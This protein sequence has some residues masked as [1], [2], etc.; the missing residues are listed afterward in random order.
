[1]W[2]CAKFVYK[3]P[4][5]GASNWSSSAWRGRTHTSQLIEKISGCKLRQEHCQCVSLF[6]PTM[7]Q[8]FTEASAAY[9]IWKPGLNSSCALI[10]EFR[11]GQG[12]QID[13]CGTQSFE[14]QSDVLLHCCVEIPNLS[15]PLCWLTSET[16]WQPVRLWLPQASGLLQGHQDRYLQTT[17]AFFLSWDSFA[18]VCFINFSILALY[19]FRASCQ[20]R[21]KWQLTN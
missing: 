3:R 15:D 20:G 17:F 9:R 12:W 2:R 21:Y 7:K 11:Y 18:F 5:R 19:C 1:M 16:L 10:V 14:H 4:S 6:C 13:K 8:K